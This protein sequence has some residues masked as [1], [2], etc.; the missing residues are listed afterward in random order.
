MMRNP[1]QPKA[2]TVMSSSCGLTNASHPFIRCHV[3]LFR[4][5]VQVASG[6]LRHTLPTARFLWRGHC[7]ANLLLCWHLT[8]LPC[9][10]VAKQMLQCR[11]TH[12]KGINYTTWLLHVQSS[13]KC[14]Q[15]RQRLLRELH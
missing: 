1:K 6:T 9:A 2:A 8:R 3:R 14:S 11:E 5:Q 7:G 12:I 13:S 4:S 15:L 10:Y